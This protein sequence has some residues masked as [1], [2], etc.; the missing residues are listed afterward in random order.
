MRIG[1][2]KGSLLVPGALAALALVVLAIWL[3]HRPG[4]DLALRVPGTDR[5]PDSEAGTGANPVL[6]GAVVRSEGQP[7]TLPGEWP[8][9]RGPNRDAISP[10]GVKLL[11]TWQTPEPREL[12][13]LELG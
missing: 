3:G 5:G 7:A 11:R 8:G 2:A 10:E 1:W 4:R 9:F 13:G 12:W 6:A